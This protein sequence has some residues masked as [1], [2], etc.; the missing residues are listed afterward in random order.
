MPREVGARAD[1]REGAA[2]Q[3]AGSGLQTR[4]RE[5]LY[6]FVTRTGTRIW[7][8]KYRYA[9]KEQRLIFGRYPDVGLAEARRKCADARRLLDERKNP[10]IEKRK[11]SMAASASAAAT[12]EKVA[13]AWHE[14]QAPRWAPVH[15]ADVIR[16]LER[17]VFPDLG[18]IPIR[19]LDAP[20]VLATLRKVERR[21]SIETAKRVRQRVSG[22]FVFGISEGWPIPIRRRSSPARSSRW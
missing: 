5:G 4:R 22:V 19:D 6:L 11:L 3:A 7:R 13:R 21:G 12:F 2:G 15:A 18:A 8:M 10:A 14:V 9:G 17:D 1:R 16:S 20:T